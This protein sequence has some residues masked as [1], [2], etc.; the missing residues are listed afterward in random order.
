MSWP[1]ET[2]GWEVQGGWVDGVAHAVA[3][4]IVAWGVVFATVMLLAMLAI[5][6]T[7]SRFWCTDARQEVEV[8]FEERGLPG[9]RKATVVSCSAFHPPTAVSCG[10]NCLNASRRPRL[11]SAWQG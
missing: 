1:A 2:V 6:H 5:R 8:T 4:G 9:F 10:R 7:R 11:A 3:W